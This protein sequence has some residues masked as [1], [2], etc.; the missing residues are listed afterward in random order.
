MSRYFRLAAW[1]CGLRKI[2]VIIST[3]DFLLTYEK[4]APISISNPSVSLS[5]V[6]L[7]HASPQL[8]KLMVRGQLMYVWHDIEITD[9][10]CFSVRFCY[11]IELLDAQTSTHCEISD[12]FSW[13]HFYAVKLEGQF[14]A[15]NIAQSLLGFLL[16]RR[17]P[18]EI[19]LFQKE[20][21]AESR[22]PFD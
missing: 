9:L 8:C 7:P 13:L 18:L 11:W 10:Y 12:K 22:T 5:L 17:N 19:L 16:S 1:I 3:L 2:I 6:N 15:W 4:Q 20:S 21:R 14:F